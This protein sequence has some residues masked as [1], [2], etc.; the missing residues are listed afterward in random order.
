MSA[1]IF[2]ASF[3]FRFFVKSVLAAEFTMLLHF[4]SVGIVLLVFLGIVVALLALLASKC[5]FDSHTDSVS[6]CLE[7]GSA[8]NPKICGGEPALIF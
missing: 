8:P 3:L 5:D 1:I 4:D 6:F 2:R 7:W